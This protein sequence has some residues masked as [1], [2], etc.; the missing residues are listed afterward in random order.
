M[1][2]N[3]DDVLFPE[4][5]LTR[6]TIWRWQRQKGHPYEDLMG[7][8]EAALNAEIMADRGAQ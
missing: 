7:E 4:H 2:S 1:S 3:E 8:F 5:L 6:A